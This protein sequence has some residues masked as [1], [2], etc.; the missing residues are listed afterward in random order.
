[1]ACRSPWSELTIR[2]YR[3]LDHAGVDDVGG[4]GGCGD[5]ADGAGLLVVEGF[6]IPSG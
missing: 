6:D 3:R 5:R 1:M 2:S 4:R